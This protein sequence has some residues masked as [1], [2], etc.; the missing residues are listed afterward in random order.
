MNNTQATGL[1]KHYLHTLERLFQHP[2]SHTLEWRD[3][4]GLVE[5]LGIVDE[6]EHGQ[7]TFTINGVTQSFHRSQHKEVSE[8]QQLVE[9]RHFMERA[10]IG[11][12]GPI[13]TKQMEKTQH[14]QVVVVINQKE[15][16]IF[17]SLG[18]ESVPERLHPEDTNGALHNLNH[19]KG[20]DK[21]SRTSENIVYYQEIATALNGSGEVL[22]M[23]NGTGASSAM[24]N[25]TDYLITHNPQ[26]ANRI[27][28]SLTLDL[29]SLTE[30]QLLQDARAFYS[31]R[32]GVV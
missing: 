7:L 9:L 25:F 24:S 21:G 1:S 18:K 13:I 4:I 27:V 32:D 6:K 16:I 20:A 11:K 28:G 15:A 10:G 31:T 22:L 5:H 30:G 12:N 17:K 19:I 3:V 2:T 14:S 29:E 26:I 23:G 8:V